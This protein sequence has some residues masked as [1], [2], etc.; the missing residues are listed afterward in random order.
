MQLCKICGTELPAGRK[1]YCD[2]HRD[3]TLV[4]QQNKEKE[5][6]DAGLCR[7]CSEPLSENSTAFCETHLIA[8]RERGV[9]DR[10]RR[11]ELGL[12]RSCS[13]PLSPKSRTWCEGHRQQH[14]EATRL[15][16]KEAREK[17]VCEDCNES[18]R[19]LRKRRCET[20]QNIYDLQRTNT[21]RRGG[22]GKPTE[23]KY[24]C[25]EHGDEENEKLRN[26]RKSLQESNKCIFCFKPMNKQVDSGYVLCHNCRAKQR[27]QRTTSAN[28]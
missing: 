18:P 11:K 12:C 16:S 17:E 15:A 14:N 2:E 8:N 22:C 25:R 13:E 28:A 5:H 19:L 26:R 4:K 10:Q 24:F 9:K 7:F 23:I 6:V 3:K 21:C 20:C 27:T 1:K